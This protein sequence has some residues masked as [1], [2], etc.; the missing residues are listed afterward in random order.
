M[1]LIATGNV[2]RLNMASRSFCRCLLKFIYP[3]VIIV[4]SIFK[5]LLGRFKSLDQSSQCSL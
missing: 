2:F 3:T 5:I 1:P 4:R